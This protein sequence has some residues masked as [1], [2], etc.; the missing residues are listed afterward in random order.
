MISHLTFSGLL[1]DVCLCSDDLPKKH[2]VFKINEPKLTRFVVIPDGSAAV[3]YVSHNPLSSN[4]VIQLQA[5]GSCSTHK[6]CHERA[7]GH[8][9]SSKDYQLYMTGTFLASDD[10]NENP[11]FASWSKVFIPYCRWEIDLPWNGLPHIRYY[12]LIHGIPRALDR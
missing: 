1:R 5:G 6:S 7:K 2:R 4:W 3:F 12:G 10:P 8:Y 11:T 9:G